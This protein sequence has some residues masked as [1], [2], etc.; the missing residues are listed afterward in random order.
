MKLA[1]RLTVESDQSKD[2]IVVGKLLQEAIERGLGMTARERTAL[3]LRDPR[4]TPDTSGNLR[5]DAK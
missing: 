3:K 5:R 1:F 4:V 2:T